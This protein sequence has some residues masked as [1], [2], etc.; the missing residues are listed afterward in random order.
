MISFMC[1]SYNAACLITL[2]MV[3]C[4]H[5]L[6]HRGNCF[7]ME[8]FGSSVFFS[9]VTLSSLQVLSVYS[10]AHDDNIL[11]PGLQL[12]VLLHR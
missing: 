12:I 4:Y 10:E 6:V 3:R 1:S 5:L 2:L 9:I 11:D 7:K 8:D